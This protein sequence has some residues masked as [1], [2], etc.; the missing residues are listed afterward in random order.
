MATPT[1]TMETIRDNWITVIEAL[2][3]TSIPSVTFHVERGE[4]DFDDL[5]ERQPDIFRRFTIEDLATYPPSEMSDMVAELL[6]T[7]VEVRVAFPKEWGIYGSNNSRDA[8]DVLR[9]D[10]FQIDKAIG[11]N[12]GANYVSGQIASKAIERTIEE[13]DNHLF[14][15]MRYSVQ[16]YRSV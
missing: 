14:A 7:E 1:T 10:M 11:H 12:G 8:R 2:T 16:F 6:E 4:V 5:A 9:E 3:P 15:L 13:T